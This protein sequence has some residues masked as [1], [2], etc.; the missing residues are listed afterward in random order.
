MRRHDAL[1]RRDATPQAAVRRRDAGRF[2]RVE[3]RARRTRDF[4]SKK[5][6]NMVAGWSAM[7]PQ[8]SVIVWAARG[9]EFVV[10]V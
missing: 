5:R 7:G 1:R 10:V 4:V 8:R 9:V 3:F 2:G 6:S